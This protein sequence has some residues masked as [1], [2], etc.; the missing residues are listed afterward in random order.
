MPSRV[1]RI[2]VFAISKGVNFVDGAQAQPRQSY[3]SLVGAAVMSPLFT[4]L[5]YS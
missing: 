2:H 1:P 5:T 3:F 4:D